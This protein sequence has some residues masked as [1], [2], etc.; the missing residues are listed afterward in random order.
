MRVA[1]DHLDQVLHPQFATKSKGIAKGLAASPG[2]AV[3]QVFFT[4]D[5]QPERVFQLNA[6]G[7]EANEFLR[8]Q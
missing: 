5:G 3:G 6:D 1:A 8:D 4:A 2:A 7:S